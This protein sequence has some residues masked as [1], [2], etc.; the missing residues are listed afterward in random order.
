MGNLR[1]GTHAHTECVLGTDRVA[2]GLAP[3]HSLLCEARTG[4]SGL[5]WEA[6]WCCKD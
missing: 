3:W 2:R 6:A 4:P 1:V 5:L